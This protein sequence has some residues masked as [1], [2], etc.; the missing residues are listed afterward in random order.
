MNIDIQCPETT[1]AQA[2]HAKRQL[3]FVM[4]RHSSRIQR[5]LVRLG[6]AQGPRGRPANYCRIRVELLD[7]QP[8]DSHDVGADLYEVI[9]RAVGRAARAVCRK[10]RS[11]GLEHHAIHER[12]HP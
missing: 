4:T 9:D 1:V 3:R 10:R 7:A 8:V 2:D 11:L 6:D 12:I 5:I